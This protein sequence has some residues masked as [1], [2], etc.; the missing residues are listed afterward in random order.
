MRFTT[1]SGSEFQ[2]ITELANTLAGVSNRK[3]NIEL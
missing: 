1:A 2:T 3:P